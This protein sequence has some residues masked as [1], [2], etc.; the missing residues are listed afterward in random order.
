[1]SKQVDERVVSMQFDNKQFENN[2]KTSMSTIDKL[3]QALN[4]KGASKGFDTI[5]SSSKQM[6]KE[7]EY[8]AYQVGFHWSDVGKKIASIWE[9]DIAGRIQSA[10]KNTVRAFTVDP[11]KTGLQEYETQLNAVQ[12][13]LANTES[14]GS[15]LEDVNKALAELNTYADKTIYNFTE[16][17]RNIGT[18]TAAGVDLETS[19]SAIQG[20]ANLAAI[21]GSTSQQAS[22][23]MYQLSQALSTGTVRL[24]DWNSVTNAGMGGE[25]FQNALKETARVH[26]VAIDD[27]LKKQGSFRESLS[28]NWLTADILTETLNHFTMAAEEGSD[29]WNEFKKSLMDDGYSE[30]QALAILKMANTAT[31][32]ATKVK[33]FTQLMD[34]LKESAQ[35]GWAQT[36]QLLIGDFE[37]AKTLWTGVSDVIG[38]FISSMSDARNKLIESAFGKTLTGM[39]EG[40]E[41]VLNV[42]SEITEPINATVESLEDL[43]GIVSKVINGD[44]GNGRERY[45]KLTE[46]GW[47]FYK[48]QNKVNETLGDSHRYTEEQ[49]KSQ[50]ELIGK[51]KKTTET[52]EEQ[53]KETKK[54]TDEQKKQIK[55]LMLMSDEQL[56]N[57]DYTEE[58][59]KAVNDLKKSFTDLGVPLDENDERFK[60][61]M[62]NLD[63]L[64]GRFLWI[65]S[66]KNLGR[67]LIEIFKAIGAAWTDTFKPITDNQ[68]FDFLV[69]FYKTTNNILN[70][71]ID[72]A[73]ELTRIFKGVFAVVDIFA[74]LFGSAFKLTFDAINAVLSGFGTDI[75]SVMAWLAD[76][77]VVVRDWI[78]AHNPIVWIFKKL[79]EFLKTACDGWR[80]WIDTLKEPDNVGRDI[81]LGLKNGIVGAAKMV[82]DTVKEFVTKIIDTAKDLLGIHSPSLVFFAI[83]TFIILGLVNGIADGF[84]LVGDVFTSLWNF[85]SNIFKS[86]IDALT[87]GVGPMLKDWWTKTKT[88]FEKL[89]PSD[90]KENESSSSS[91][92]STGDA[93]VE[94]TIS[95]WDKVK[96]AFTDG[97]NWIKNAWDVVKTWFVDT[98]S[99][100]DWGTIISV[101]LT[102]GLVY[103]LLSISKA[104]GGIV[105]LAET[106]ADLTERFNKL[107][108]SMSFKLVTEGILNLAQAMLIIVGA[109]IILAYAF[110]KINVW[111]ILGSILLVALMFVGLAF[112]MKAI[113]NVN[114]TGINIDTT[115]FTLGGLA[116]A[117]L[118]FA[119][120]V[121]I[122]AGIEDGAAVWRAGAVVAIFTGIVVGLV[123]V[124]RLCG[125]KIFFVGTMLTSLAFTLLMLGWAIKIVGSLS[126]EDGTFQKGAATIGVFLVLVTAIVAFTSFGKNDITKLATLFLSISAVFLV[127]AQA[128]KTIGALE[129]SD[130]GKGAAVLGGTIV[131]LGII[132]WL[133][134]YVKFDAEL[135]KLAALF[136]SVAAV[137]VAIAY[138]I[139]TLG[140][141]TPEQI[142]Q[143]QNVLGTILVLLG[144]ITAVLKFGKGHISKNVAAIGTLF[145]GL[146][147]ALMGIA[148]AVKTLGRMDVN[149][150]VSGGLAVTIIM[151]I[152]VL[153][154]K[155]MAETG[156][157]IP[158][159][160]GL[161]M[162]LGAALLAISISIAVLTML[163]PG[164]M[165][166][167][168]GAISVLIGAISLILLASKNA[169]SID[170]GMFIGLT[171]AVAAIAL[172]L[173]ALSLIDP[174]KLIAPMTSLL[175]LMGMFALMMETAKNLDKDG[176][177]KIIVMTVAIGVI[178]AA[179]AVLSYMDTE[180]MLA[181]ALAVSAVL[182]VLSFIMSTLDNMKI[183]IGKMMTAILGI[184]CLTVIT[185][186][187]AVVLN[188]VSGLD[189]LQALAMT[190]VIALFLVAMT[191]IAILAGLAGPQALIGV[192]AVAILT[193]LAAGIAVILLMVKDLDPAQSL[194]MALVISAFILIMTG[195]AAILGAALPILAPA[196]AGAALL[197]AIIAILFGGITAVILAASY[198]LPLIGQNLS[199]FVDNA[200][201]FIDTVSSIDSG[202][203]DGITTLVL[204]I[205]A[206]TAAELVTSVTNFFTKISKLFGGK[207]PLEETLDNFAEAIIGFSEKISGKIDVDAINAATKAFQTLGKIE[208]ID[209]SKLS[210][211]VKSMEKLHKLATNMAKAD[212]S[213]MSA[214]GEALEKVAE[215]GITKFTEA[216][217]NSVDEV[218]Q[219]I[220]DMLSSAVTN[221]EGYYAGFAQVGAY[222]VDG[223]GA[224]IIS[225][226]ATAA[227]KAAAVAAAAMAAME[228]ELDEHSPSKETYRIGK[229]AGQGFVNAFIDYSSTAFTAGSDL[230]KSASD[231]LTKALSQVQDIVDSDMDVQ[232]TIRPVLDLSDVRSGVGQINGLL[233]T[234]P[235]VGVEANISSIKRL[236]QN[237]QNGANTDVVDAIEMLSKK[238]DELPS[239]DT[240]SI[241]GITYD[242]GSNI[243]EAVGSI[244]RAARIERRI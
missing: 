177:G 216:F 181:G 170:K 34:T 203:M 202:L 100:I 224:G 87:N 195:I 241:N 84:A 14:K 244:V 182:A 179:L 93:V 106:F 157:K 95:F 105:E 144:G 42:T 164:K 186:G 103:S 239:G 32:A 155:T 97:W 243:A 83:G 98:F 15:T 151:G 200:Q 197:V 16:M 217:D 17:T 148:F 54:L 237:N 198:A 31:D 120:C 3:K 21:S 185:A 37:E 136:L 126:T 142:Q 7:S 115:I 40:L 131:I 145:I 174:D 133:V 123:A 50:D 35:S 20:I 101:A 152:M 94:E 5:N 175:I 135:T 62:D 116:I 109:I 49:I 137:A 150:L 171:I 36:W 27:I 102:A 149:E 160:A 108:G 196:V 77:I 68:V 180:G 206:I 192:A 209:S 60:A 61:L 4:F 166:S 96:R 72:N 230:A 38:G 67:S 204:A 153:M 188:M 12:T 231:G 52:T 214:F 205:L 112:L 219:S 225:K 158:K 184:A 118:A 229:F 44:F 201:K 64:N 45:S 125:A 194:Q 58:Q 236:M 207:S 71:I 80:T 119:A 215:A 161:F 8:A 66:I 65:E 193:V 140:S 89:F 178:A 138:S 234:N 226:K 211:A 22:T 25:V 163:D 63:N 233:N 190:G 128:M 167:A 208:S 78:D 47:N 90:K 113:N 74:T 29:E 156:G 187:I 2:V 86:G 117:L 242:D 26:G 46:S 121:A 56:K 18:F 24:M 99:K 141:L 223:F 124:A 168:V 92:T 57:A 28:E 191:G 82:F 165:W 43:D 127:V 146:A 212:Y 213:G 169:T 238:F 30:E 132:G 91:D 10:L 48:V 134:K 9:Y 81:V 59:I 53:K 227:G 176:I 189:P 147:A 51:T 1:M 33:T 55:S 70:G 143:A 173:A 111:A 154:A 130:I 88:S 13:I 221:I 159:V 6:V 75:L 76:G 39:S 69:G 107:M 232:P 129:W 172:A 220:N 222:L 240:Y 199:D 210:S 73:S 19:V 139:K 85:I 23:A 235:S 162:S 228:A 218:N 110:T 11:I 104:L 122:I 41:K 183:N 114:N 79:G